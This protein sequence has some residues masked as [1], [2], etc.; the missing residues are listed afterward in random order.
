MIFIYDSNVF[1]NLGSYFFILIIRYD[2]HEITNTF[3]IIL[4]T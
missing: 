4:E 1:K 2:F 3:M